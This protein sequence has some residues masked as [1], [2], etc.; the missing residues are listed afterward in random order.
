[1]P[2]YFNWSQDTLAVTTVPK[3]HHLLLFGA[4]GTTPWGPKLEAVNRSWSI[5]SSSINDHK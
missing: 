3:K 5:M 1:M 4:N 2:N